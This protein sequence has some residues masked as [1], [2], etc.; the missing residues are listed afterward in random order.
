M[1]GPHEEAA[2]T[3]PTSH[4]EYRR[5][6]PQMPHL[7]VCALYSDSDAISH[8]F[9]AAAHEGLEAAR[10]KFTT[11]PD[12]AVVEEARA[13]R[14]FNLAQ[15]RA[16]ATYTDE[17]ARA[18]FAQRASLSEAEL[19]SIAVVLA[20]ADIPDPAPSGVPGL[21]SRVGH[22]AAR[23]RLAVRQREEL[24]EHAIAAEDA[25][26]A[27]VKFHVAE[28]DAHRAT[29]NKIA[30]RL[31]VVHEDPKILA[32]AIA[33]VEELVQERYEAQTLHLDLDDIMWE[34]EVMGAKACG[35]SAAL[36]E[37]DAAIHTLRQSHG[38][39]TLRDGMNLLEAARQMPHQCVTCA[40]VGARAE[41]RVAVQPGRSLIAGRPVRV[42]AEPYGADEITVL[43]ESIPVLQ[44]YTVDDPPWLSCLEVANGEGRAIMRYGPFPSM[45]DAIHEVRR[46]RFV[47]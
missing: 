24:S 21:V 17:A 45:G 19:A 25:W 23:W 14:A 35:L 16:A 43:N 46:W 26:R 34:A 15:A 32:A 22:L 28:R 3:C 4:K 27:R 36:A 38:L 33:M 2:C 9:I 1:P 40:A 7:S 41:R 6:H 47:P 12:P 44:R 5:K 8:V 18:E 20:G 11:S 13:E 29:L 37:V 31:H 30:D 10:D 42:W 39:T